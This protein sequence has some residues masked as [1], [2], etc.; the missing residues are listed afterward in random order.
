MK[1]A[2]VLV[3]A[4][5]D[6]PAELLQGLEARGCRITFGDPG[7][8]VP[9]E[10]NARAFVEAIADADV[11]MG[12]SIRATP[13]SR[14]IMQ[15]APKLRLIVKYTV[16]VDDIDIEA[17]TKLGI[18][19]CHAPTEDNCF[20]V[21]ENTMA[22]MLAILKKI[23]Q[24]DADVRAGNWRLPQHAGTFLGA[25]D[26]DGYP[27]ITVGIVGLGRVG[28]RFAQLLQPWRVRIIAYDPHV[29]PM[30]FLLA[31]VKAVDYATLLQQSDVISYHPVLNGETYNMCGSKEISAMKSS[32][33]V[34]NTAR[35][36]V[37]DESALAHALREGRIAAAAIDAF[38]EEPLDRKSPL[39]DLGDRIILSPHATAF[40]GPGELRA[41]VEWAFRTVHSVLSGSVPDNVYNKG[42]MGRWKG[43]F[44]AAASV[45]RS[46]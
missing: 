45:E 41:G 37:V 42:V 28:T 20:A 7:W 8:L 9:D 25:R 24:R 21:A 40:N 30:K 10:N 3:Y 38:S 32:A 11:L 17:A 13:I 22:L 1:S 46:G 4:S 19:V 39:R 23:R 36:N 29:E 16:G 5:C 31:G 34:I 43:R 33:V 15:A 2:N 26:S 18:M 44:Q 27:G 35:G 6:E 14:R 12:T